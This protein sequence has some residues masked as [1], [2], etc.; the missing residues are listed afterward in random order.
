MPSPA[1]T[2]TIAARK[3]SRVIEVTANR[4]LTAGESGS[5]VVLNKSDSATVTLPKAQAGIEFTFVSKAAPGSGAGYAISP[6]AADKINYT[7]GVTNKDLI[8]TQATA[9]LGDSVRLV[10]ISTTEWQVA[11]VT[12]T[13]AKEP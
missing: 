4:T 13:W 2:N 11:G 3:R 5:I 7:T 12:G 9:A 10:G 8:N 6:N 1:R